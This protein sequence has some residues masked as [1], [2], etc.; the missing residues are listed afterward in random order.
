MKKIKLIF[1]SFKEIHRLEKKL[2]PSVVL[3]SIVRSLLPF[4]NIFFTAK[5]LELF[6]N[7]ATFTECFSCISIAL[8]LNLGL[9]FLESYLDD[10]HLIYRSL[11]YSKELQ[12]IA[13]KLFN[14]EYQKLENTEFKD[15]IHKHTESQERVSSAFTHDYYIFNH[16]FT[17]FSNWFY[18]HR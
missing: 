15:L 4:V 17:T 7:K 16:Y 2:L 1:A 8:I 18:A 3:I 10:T 5:L 14:T 9:F 6:S 12:C 13:E 11:M